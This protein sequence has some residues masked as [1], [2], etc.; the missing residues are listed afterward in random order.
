MVIDYWEYQLSWNQHEKEDHE[1]E[2]LHLV[3]MMIT[4]I[5]EIEKKGTADHVQGPMKEEEEIDHE[6]IHILMFHHDQ[7]HVQ[8]IET[9]RRNQRKEED[10]ET[11]IMTENV[12]H[13]EEV[14][15]PHVHDH[16]L[17]QNQIQDLHHVQDHD[18]MIENEEEI[19]QILNHQQLDHEHHLNHHQSVEKK[20][21]TEIEKES[22]QNQNHAQDHDHHLNLNQNHHHIHHQNHNQHQIQVIKS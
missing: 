18:L 14:I 21:E 13:T 2:V 16:A 20:E 4:M 15:H 9:E 8:E 3:V 17:Y 1:E 12:N 11:E 5:I 6:A 7:D 22:H 19:D 10:Q